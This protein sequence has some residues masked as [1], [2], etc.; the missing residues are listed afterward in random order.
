MIPIGLH[1]RETTQNRK[2]NLID[3]KIWTIIIF[4]EKYLIYFLI[5][6][7]FQNLNKKY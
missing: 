3:I 7:Y 6:F 5:T 4:K 2:K 1:N